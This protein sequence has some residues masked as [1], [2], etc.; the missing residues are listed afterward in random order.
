M[1]INAQEA[2]RKRREE[3]ASREADRKLTWW[4]YPVPPEDE[5]WPFIDTVTG[6]PARPEM[7]NERWHRVRAWVERRS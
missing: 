5:P 7:H 3:L 4:N 2:E 6:V 1:V